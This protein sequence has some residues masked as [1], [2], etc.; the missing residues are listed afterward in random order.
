MHAQFEGKDLDAVK[1]DFNSQLGDLIT[2]IEEALKQVKTGRASP[3]IF[4]HLE[5]T[6][7]GEKH[8]F[9]DLCQVIVKGS[10]QL[11]VRVFDDAAKDDVIKAL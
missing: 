2:D 3:N 10:N 5:V 4:D 9:T 8:P 6:A 7:Y 11:L 1:K